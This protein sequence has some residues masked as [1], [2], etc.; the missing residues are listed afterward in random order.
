MLCAAPPCLARFPPAVYPSR[1][2]VALFNAT[3]ST[4]LGFRKDTGDRPKAVFSADPDL[5]WA[6][7]LGIFMMLFQ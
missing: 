6:R 3:V 7:C 2:A 4:Y 1:R 5:T